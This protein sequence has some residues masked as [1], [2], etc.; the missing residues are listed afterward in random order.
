V[1]SEVHGRRLNVEQQSVTSKSERAH[2]G[3]VRAVGP[4]S[5]NFLEV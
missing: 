2:V 3:R 4:M 1:F 5:P